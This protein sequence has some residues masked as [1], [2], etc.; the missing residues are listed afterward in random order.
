MKVASFPTIMT[1]RANFVLNYYWLKFKSGITEENY[2]LAMMFKQSKKKTRFTYSLFILCHIFLFSLYLASYLESNKVEHSPKSL[3]FKLILIVSLILVNLALFFAKFVFIAFSSKKSG[4]FELNYFAA[5]LI[6]VFNSSPFH[7]FTFGHSDNSILCTLGIFALIIF[8]ISEFK[9]NYR[10]LLMYNIIIC[11]FHGVI[12]LL[13][14]SSN[15]AIIQNLVLFII[16]IYHIGICYTNELN[17]RNNYI[18][19]HSEILKDIENGQSQIDEPEY[20]FSLA[21]CIQELQN[22]TQYITT[23][24]KVKIEKVIKALKVI[25]NTVAMQDSYY[26]NFADEIDEEDK[27]Y[28]QQSCLPNKIS[29]PI[30]QKKFKQ[31]RTL[32]SIVEKVLG[33][34]VII[35]LKQ[36]TSNWNIDMFQL[37]EKSGFMPITIVGRYCMKLFNLNENLGIADLKLV[38]F[39]SEIQK[40]YKNNPYHNAVHAAD[41]LV[42]GLYLLKNSDLFAN[43]LD[44]EMLTV[45]I[46]HLTHDIAH[47][48]LNNRFL[49]NFGDDLAIECKI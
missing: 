31:R 11:A 26:E 17:S 10:H 7:Y 14:D 13:H 5:C 47:P 21:N 38:F 44:I 12:T 1:D 43:L 20:S 32:E 19:H 25:Q 35:L 42:S 45:I 33:Q 16:C 34:E 40:Q 36:V 49:I 29:E 27:I 9:F 28:I 39:L 3:I 46:S 24:P 41:V 37:N 18:S 23:K 48:G 6:L 22:A 8:N 4:I 30:T 15:K 2:K